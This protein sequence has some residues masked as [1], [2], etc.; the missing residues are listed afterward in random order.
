MTDNEK[1]IEVKYLNWVETYQ[2]THKTIPFRD[3][4]MMREAYLA[5]LAEGRGE[6]EILAKGIRAMQTLIENSRGV[7]GLHL[8]GEIAPWSSLEK[9]GQFEDWLFDFSEAL[10][11]LEGKEGL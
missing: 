2:R 5:G 11:I 4:G 3:V 6:R 8:N 1:K 9:H 10:S 7:E